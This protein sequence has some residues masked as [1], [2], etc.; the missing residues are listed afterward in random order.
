MQFI[1]IDTKKIIIFWS[2]KCG[3][4]TLKTILAIFFNIENNKNKDIH[5]NEELSVKIDK[6]DKNK[7]DIYKN[8]DIVMLIRNPYERLVSGFLNKYAFGTYKNPS[9]C[10]CFYDFCSILQKDPKKI[11]KHHFEKQ[12]KG[13]GWD[14]YNELQRPKIKYILNTSDV[15][16]IRKILGLNIPE[17]KENYNKKVIENNEEME[18]TNLWSLDYKKLKKLNNINYFYF[19][20]D[21]IKNLVYNIYKDDFMFFNNNLNMNYTI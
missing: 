8:Y 2:P 18:K 3:C 12:T 5:L 19:Y 10:N 16:D 6:K 9:N 1:I 13:K 21:D 20:N 14:F 15:N 7:M 4:T 11:N 17:I